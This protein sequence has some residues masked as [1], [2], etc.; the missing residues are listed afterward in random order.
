MQ[1]PLLSWRDGL[2]YHGDQSV[3]A[4]RLPERH[5]HVF[6]VFVVDGMVRE[7]RS[8]ASGDVGMQA[9]ASAI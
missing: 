2:P 9:F 8:I 4:V 6:T 7:S 1:V 5:A 3:V